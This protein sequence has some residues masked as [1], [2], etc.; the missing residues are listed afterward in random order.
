MAELR[1]DA[2][3][4]GAGVE[5]GQT[6]VLGAPRRAADLQDVLPPD[7]IWSR[8]LASDYVSSAPAA[9]AQALGIN[10]AL[11]AAGNAAGNAADAG[12]RSR[13]LLYVPGTEIKMEPVV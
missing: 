8:R 9:R 2:G 11:R 1:R 10:L 5:S 13:T 4:A 3:G 6:G 12:L 7:H